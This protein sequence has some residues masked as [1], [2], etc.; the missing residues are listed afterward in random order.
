MRSDTIGRHHITL[1]ENL[2][3]EQCFVGLLKGG[4][5]LG[6]EFLA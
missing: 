5:D 2:K 3:P 1:Y 6:G 4:S